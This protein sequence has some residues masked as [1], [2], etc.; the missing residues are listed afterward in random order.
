MDSWRGGRGGG[1][2]RTQYCQLIVLFYQVDIHY[3]IFLF[4]SRTCYPA[5]I[6]VF[7]VF[8][9]RDILVSSTV[10]NFFLKCSLTQNIL[11]VSLC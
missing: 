11:D 7:N 9:Y 4:D 1:F 8:R 5:G 2:E 10:L 3:R 6:L